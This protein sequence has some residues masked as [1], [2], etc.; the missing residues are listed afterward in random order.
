MPM[1]SDL[2]EGKRSTNERIG[3]GD[4]KLDQPKR[5]RAPGMVG[6]ELNTC[7]DRPPDL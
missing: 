5:N 6:T 7:V 4:V 1:P 2:R 3:R